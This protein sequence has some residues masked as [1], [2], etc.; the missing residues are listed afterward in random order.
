MK[1]CPKSE[2]CS[3]NK[4]GWRCKVW[5]RSLPVGKLGPFFWTLKECLFWFSEDRFA[6]ISELVACPSVICILS[7][8]WVDKICMLSGTPCFHEQATIRTQVKYLLSLKQKLVKFFCSIIWK[9]CWT[10]SDFYVLCLKVL[11]LTKHWF[12]EY[13]SE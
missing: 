5:S 6:Q 9:F 4:W 2:L 3:K 1:E 12:L 8:T 7:G 11:F 13:L 10:N